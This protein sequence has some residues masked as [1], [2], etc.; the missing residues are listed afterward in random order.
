MVRI[1]WI[2]DSPLLASGFGRVTKEIVSRLAVSED[3][4]FACLGW[5]Y[6]GW[7]YAREDFP[8]P[9]YP[10]LAN[11]QG[12][13][14]FERVIDEFKPDVVVTLGEL[15][16]LDWLPAHPARRR[17]K[18]VAY[19]PVDGGPFY[20]PWGAILKDADEL[21]AMS[22]FG[23]TILQSGLSDR[24]INLIPHGVNTKC[25]RPLE[26]RDTLR[27]HPRLANKFIIGCVARNQARKN[28]PALVSAFAEVATINPK[29]HLYLHMNPCD[30]GFD[31]VTLLHR[32]RLH[33][34]ADISDPEVGVTNP[35]TDEQLNRV[36]NLM[37]VMVLP[38]LG[39]GF[40]LPIIESLSAGV[41]VVATDC[42]ACSELV[43]GRGELVSTAA[44]ITSGLNLITQA[45]ISEADL[46]AKLLQVMRDPALLRRYSTAG[47]DFA[48]TLDWDQLAPTW[49]RLLTRLVDR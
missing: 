42:S 38:T 29:A 22:Q 15:W 7:P 26:N 39:E 1:L 31:L 19:V 28:I 48:L 36:Y 47:R 44:V 41:P 4:R 27:N 37:D 3:L 23:K 5:G 24:L 16:M 21:V 9:I 14:V 8:V 13:S 18:W 34:K 40:G 6:D 25:F 2:S 10:V 45:I 33:G 49:Y 46:V 43:R 12:R 11:D 20:P 32:H 17:I 30:V 35:I